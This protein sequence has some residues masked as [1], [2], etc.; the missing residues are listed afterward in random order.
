MCTRAEHAK[1]DACDEES[2]LVPVG[3]KP[4][5]RDAEIDGRGQDEERARGGDG[6]DEAHHGLE[7]L[8]VDADA[9]DAPTMAN[10]STKSRAYG[11]LPSDELKSI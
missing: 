10:V 4:R 7:R 8:D 11:A 6:A 9:Q 5:R 1:R 3:G 2:D